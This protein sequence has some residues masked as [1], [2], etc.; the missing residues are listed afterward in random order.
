V[1]FTAPYEAF[2]L[3][4]VPDTAAGEAAPAAARGPGGA[5]RNDPCPCGSG[6]KY[7]KCCLGRDEDARAAGPERDAGGAA[8]RSHELDGRLL[9]ELSDFA[10]RSFGAEW[11]RFLEDFFD[12]EAAIQLSAHWSVYHQRVRGETV[13]DR[14]LEAHARRLS[15]AERAWLDAQRAAWL[16][17]WEVTDVAPGEGMT[18]RDLL[19]GEGRR[20]REASGSRTA[21][22][23][24]A[25]LARVVDHAGVS[26]VC[27]AHP[28]VLSPMEA[29]EVVRRARG[30]LRRR[31]E[32]PLE[33]LRD[34]AFGRYLIRRWEESVEE[35]EARAAV[36]PQLS[37]TDGEP[38]LLTTDHFEI[39]PGERP[40]VEAALAALEGAQPPEP[41]EDPAVYGF[42]RPGNAVHE[43]WP[44]TVVG[45]ARLSGAALALETNS[46]E[47]ADA[48]RARVEAVCGGR[49]RHR[50]REH[51]DPLSSRAAR[52]RASA[53][54]E[55]SGPEV[56]KLEREWKQRYYAD[57][58]DQ[59]IP[60][61]G[62]KTP[63]EAAR[64]AQGRSA[65]DVLLKEME[66]HEQ[67][68]T[69]GARFDFSVLRRELGLE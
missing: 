1:R 21:V 52:G 8:Q 7:K 53:P 54:P 11:L 27:G 23:R 16:S 64:S 46:R 61:L 42:L 33:R 45:Q 56:E 40:A 44:N 10:V 48:L 60:A 20:V 24:D 26:L 14:Y 50:A 9:R 35:M 5:G 31:R 67:R 69:S 62:G 22:V 34:D 2:P 58:L 47:R 65:L 59:S 37:N 6:R 39:A 32:V 13:A 3:F 15:R 12:P 18:L 63:R 19:S 25:M 4:D 36:P 29:A 38:F 30:R 49:I 57:W 51:A 66:N 68:S 55:P 41:G 17:V 43:S 28:R